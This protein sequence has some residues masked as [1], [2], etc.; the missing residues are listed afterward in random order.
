MKLLTETVRFIE[1]HF[2]EI[3]AQQCTSPHCFT[4]FG[5]KYCSDTAQ[6]TSSSSQKHNVEVSRLLK[7]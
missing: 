2:M 4:I 1:K 5:P 6:S 7:T 3:A